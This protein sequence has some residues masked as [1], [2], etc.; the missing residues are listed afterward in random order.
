MQTLLK[1]LKPYR[2]RL[3][4]VAVTDAVGMLTA[5]LMPYVMS[6][7]V[8][9]GIAGGDLSV[10]LSSAAVMLILAIISITGGLIANKVNTGITT[11]Y[12]RDV[13]R[14][15]FERVNT[16]SY[17][18]Y[19]KIGPSGLLTRTTDDIFNIEGAAS[20]L[21][22][23]I[24]TVPVMLVGS[25][26][27]AFLADAM[28]A[29]VF[30]LA[31]PPVMII[32]Y[33]F[34]RPLYSMW[35]KSDKYVDEQNKIV[36][37]RLGALRV[38]RAFNNEDREHSRAKHAT[39]EMAKYMIRANVRGGYIEPVAMLLLNIAT[40]VM[41][42][43]GGMRAEG[44]LLHDAGDV[45]AVVQYVA[46]ISGALLN[47][48]WTI[49]WL[50]RL[51][52]SIR[53]IGEIHSSHGERKGTD[54]VLTNGFGIK[55]DGLSFTY[56]GGKEKVLFDISF[57]VKEGERVAIIGG[58]GSGKSTLVRLLLGFF[59]AEGEITLGGA[60]YSE[61]SPSVIREHYSAALQ[62]GMIFEGTVR[63][64]IKMGSPEADDGKIISVLSD[65]AMDT[66]LSEHSEGLDYLL[67]GSGTN[68]S[69]GQRQ[70][71]NMARTVIRDADI[72]IF[73]DSFSALDFLTESKIKKN[74]AER[75]SGKT[76]III[77]QRV[78]TAMSCER[79][80]VLDRGKIVGTG[81]HGELIKSSDI[82]REI[83]S[84][85]LG[86]EYAEGVVSI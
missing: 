12:T 18:E 19:S 51:R 57:S 11:G 71:L 36:R 81:T 9:T 33:F 60:R 61:L 38:V 26:I 49:A 67:V 39:E 25:V 30:M 46:L 48:S 35:D 8:D 44:G 78:S 20:S 45:I 69:G 42:A 53:R 7:I 22:Y 76:Q 66:F 58:T 55:V 43:V 75:L 63:D 32:I 74:L 80:I 37:E 79:I 70:R 4:A 13:C 50:P 59:D 21:V 84:S 3:A 16:L 40:V 68:V 28:L 56:P 72:Y 5:M 27:L 41:I 73:D 47:L 24:V 65:C 54:G 85:Q 62:R 77:T 2:A 17:E 82:Y 34:M 10:I 1:L 23:T 14:A 83:C 52:V 86:R 29:L 15:T 31:I 6:R 64:N